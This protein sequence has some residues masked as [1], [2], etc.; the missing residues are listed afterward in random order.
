MSRVVHNIVHSGDCNVVSYHCVVWGLLVMAIGE[1]RPNTT[2]I[3]VLTD[4]G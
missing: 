4:G 1:Q 3:S 2:A